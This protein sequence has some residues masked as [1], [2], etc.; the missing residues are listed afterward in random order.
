MKSK[1][2][3]T[4]VGLVGLCSSCETVDSSRVDNRPPE[5]DMALSYGTKALNFAIIDRAERAAGYD[6]SIYQGSF[7]VPLH[8]YV[9]HLEQPLTAK[10]CTKANVDCAEEFE[11]TQCTVALDTCTQMVATGKKLNDFLAAMVQPGHVSKILADNAYRK[12]YLGFARELIKKG[13]LN[14]AFVAELQML[15]R[16]AYPDTVRMRL[17]SSTN[18]EDLPGLS[19]AGLYTSQ[20]ACL[21]DGDGGDGA[22][23]CM[24]ATEKARLQQRISQLTAD[25]PVRNLDLINDMTKDLTKKRPIDKAVKKVFASVWN[26]KAFLSRDFYGMDHMKVAMAMLVHPSFADEQAN[27]VIVATTAA[28]GELEVNIVAQ[29]DDVSITNPEI[30]GAT[31]DQVIMTKMADGNYTEPRFTLRSNQTAS[32]TSVL[33]TAQM[34]EL[35]DQVGVAI[36]ALRE[37][38]GAD[39]GPRMDIE[40]KVDGA[41]KILM[42]QGRPL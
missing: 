24:S 3:Y 14:P 16:Q 6:R 17:R 41:G 5:R 33:T 31:P 28:S 26:E 32:G 11:A 1:L 2:G 20:A 13:D 37:V 10:M 29:K 35:V 27:G 22:S 9:R 42:K 19:G 12:A 38:Y 30:P 18:A 34:R 39:Y 23:L 4:L 40:F 8:F 7:A 15:I 21:A 25:D 36:N